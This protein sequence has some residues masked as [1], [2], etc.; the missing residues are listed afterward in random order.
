MKNSFF[1]VAS[2]CFALS[3]RAQQNLTLSQCREMALQNN[4][5]IKAAQSQTQSVENTRK[6][7]RANYFP[8][9]DLNLIGL[10]STANGELGYDI[11]SMAAGLSG[12]GQVIAYNH[13]A[14]ADKLS[15]VSL[16]DKIGI[17][18]EVGPMFIAGVSLQQPIYM[19]GKIKNATRIASMGVE[20]AQQNELLSKANVIKQTDEA[21]ALVIKAKEM[22]KVAKRYNDVLVELLDN[23]SK[24]KNRG[25]KTNN[26]VLKVQVKLNES[27]L[28]MQKADNAVVL[29]KMNL[30][31]VV[32]LDLNSDIDVDD[33]YPSIEAR[34]GSVAQ[35]PESQILQK[36]VDI[37][38]AKTQVE[39]SALRP[40]V[41]ALLSYNYVNGFEVNDDKLFN[42]GSFT[43]LIKVKVP[44]VNFGKNSNKVKAAQS[45]LEQ[46]RL[47]QK[48]LTEQM[49][50]EQQRAKN[51]LAEAQTELQVADKSL[52]QAS[53]NLRASQSQYAAGTESLSDV[54]EA[55]LLW[56]Q[57]MANVV[58]AKYQVYLS[59]VD[60]NR[61]SGTLVD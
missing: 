1:L 9:I 5:E 31:H 17:D 20:M 56:Q 7:Y 54:L 30:C 61:T 57:A 15:A 40:E 12:I 8:S 42:D 47:E 38:E 18:Y 41:G 59:I 58:N 23:V 50:L 28:A 39:K 36:K 10:Y 6:S 27:Q 32:G 34:D 25:M 14:F 43:A 24:A 48:N 3:A 55:Q 45:S 51:N 60:L 44:L 52:A 4:S 2:L 35:R 13:P 22:Q 53:E 33:E 37:A 16:P 46:T 19:G 29:A 26:D 21:Y 49:E 11:S